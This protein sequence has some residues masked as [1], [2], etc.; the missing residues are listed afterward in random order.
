MQA[1]LN[2][3]TANATITLLGSNISEG[4]VKLPA[5]L[6]NITIKGDG[7]TTVLKDTT[8]MAADGTTLNYDGLT[9][10]GI[11]FDNSNIVLTGWRTSASFSNL[12]IT[13]CVFKNVVRDSNNQAA[14]HINVSDDNGEAINGFTE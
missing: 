10:D 14:V 7:E 1:A 9:F 5:E 6:K 3:A 12:T 4:T 2:A 8:I 13:N 11:V